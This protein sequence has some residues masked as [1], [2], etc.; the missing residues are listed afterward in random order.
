M[1]SISGSGMDSLRQTL[2]SYAAAH[3]RSVAV[4]V[5]SEATVLDSALVPSQGILLRSLV[6]CGTL[7]LRDEF[8][9]GL[10]AGRVRSITDLQRHTVQ[11]ATPGMVVGITGVRKLPPLLR[12]SPHPLPCG[13]TLFVRSKAEIDAIW[14][15]R[16]LEYAFKTSRCGEGDEE[17]ATMGVVLVADNANSMNTLLDHVQG[18]PGVSIVY[19]RVGQILES[20][21]Q[22]CRDS[23][24][25]LVSYNVP[26]PK[27]CRLGDQFVYSRLMSSLLSDVDKL[28][29]SFEA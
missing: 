4:D 14:E 10:Y 18:L 24:A 16:M 17:E 28:V 19:S 6:Q 2:V 22:V 20:D 8:I 7:R 21:V 1:S 26:L 23:N 27:N 11:Q 29:K 25:F 13:D 15:Q 5:P 3:P 9:C 12:R